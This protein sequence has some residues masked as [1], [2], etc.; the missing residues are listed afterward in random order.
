MSTF[1]I[2]MLFRLSQ[3]SS[4]LTLSRAIRV[5]VW[6]AVSSDPDL[7]SSIRREAE[8]K[9]SGNDENFHRTYQ[10][11]GAYNLIRRYVQ[12]IPPLRSEADPYSHLT[13]SIHMYPEEAEAVRM[14][15]RDESPE[16]QARRRRR[17]EAIV[18]NEGDRPI[19]SDDIIQR[20]M[21][22]YEMNGGS[23]LA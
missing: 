16:E 1:A 6:R 4:N 23:R 9:P 13:D 17:R 19:T 3:T 8:A 2:R 20:S 14:R 10:A 11:R 7:L 21:E 15:P 12:G 18:L 5:L 22:D